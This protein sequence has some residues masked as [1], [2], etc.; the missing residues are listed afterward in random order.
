LRI[1][2]A[3]KAK[4]EF[5]EDT[6][7][8]DENGVTHRVVNWVVTPEEDDQ[9]KQ[10]YRCP[11][12]MQAFPEA[13]PDECPICK[14]TPSREWFSPKKHQSMIYERMHLGT[15]KYG[16][17]EVNDY[18]YDTVDWQPKTSVLLPGKDF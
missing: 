1:E 15:H 13:F 11:F 8:I 14:L 18:D 5:L 4:S 6:Q 10:G 9:I 2:A 7:V 3:L 12:D 16:P 17:T